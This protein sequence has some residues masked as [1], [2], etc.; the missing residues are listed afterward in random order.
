MAFNPERLSLLVQPIGDGGIRFFGYQT[1]DAEATVTAASYATNASDYGLRAY[2]LIVVTPLS[3]AEDTYILAVDTIDADGHA[4]LASPGPIGDLLAANNL[5][6]IPD[7]A[8]ALANLGGMAKATY[9]PG[10]VAGDAF[11]MD[12]M[13]E[14]TDTKILTAAER[15]AIAALGT[16]ANADLLDDDTFAGATAANVPSAESTKAYVDLRAPAITANT[17]LVDNAAGTL[18]EAKAFADV[19]LSLTVPPYVA[20]RT[21][22]KALDET[23]DVRAYLGET[24]RAGF[25]KAVLTSSLSAAEQAAATA[26]TAEGIYVTS[27]SYTWVREEFTGENFNVGWFHDW[28]TADI[29]TACDVAVA[30]M[31]ALET[32]T[33]ANIN[34][35][36]ARVLR[37]PA[38]DWTKSG[39][40]TIRQGGVHLTSD[41]DTNLLCT[42]TGAAFTFQHANYLDGQGLS[43]IQVTG[44]H[45]VRAT[46]VDGSDYYLRFYI[47]RHVVVTRNKFENGTIHVQ[48]DAAF[49]PVF[50]YNNI[51]W[52]GDTAKTN[53]YSLRIRVLEVNNGTS[54]A[55]V[56]ADDGKD[57]FHNSQVWVYANEMR[58]LVGDVQ[59]HIYVEDI[60]GFQCFQNHIFNGEVQVQ[61]QPVIHGTGR[62]TNCKVEHNFFDGG[63]D[64]TRN[65]Y[66]GA[67]SGTS[68]LVAR[69]FL[70]SNKFNQASTLN[71]ESD[72]VLDE[73]HVL[74]NEFD[75]CTGTGMLR[76]EGGVAVCRIHGNFFRLSASASPSTNCID[77]FMTS[78]NQFRILTIKANLFGEDES[79]A[80]YPARAIL[81]TGNSTNACN[82]YIDDNEYDAG[83]A[84]LTTDNSGANVTVTTGTNVSY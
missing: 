83:F 26:D 58:S 46:A 12:N 60:D 25:F 74:D 28:S 30:V 72:L 32:R 51:F 78:K 81:L 27:G 29:E 19:R 47:C 77:I 49:E 9:D 3:G 18:R 2:D 41:G 7:P 48:F 8:T 75:I 82:I 50:V 16:A 67:L 76:T 73:F 31:E 71:V 20:D 62:I 13:V 45:F 24:G 70:R 56:D 65:L 21:A 59:S 44:I 23:K 66:V 39:N 43:H 15:A 38:G 4:T 14:G 69:L 52:H 17:M 1:D 42:G 34:T 40:T 55:L 6:D 37:L 5:S 63:S 84:A 11:A 80:T 64:T 10:N 53:A 22:L 36:S 57:Y 35:F 61:F 68:V 79:G 54:G 33:I